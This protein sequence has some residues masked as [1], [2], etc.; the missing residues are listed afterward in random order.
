M[1]VSLKLGTFVAAVTPFIWSVVV[2][3]GNAP[4]PLSISIPERPEL[5]P[6]QP[7][8]EATGTFLFVN[9]GKAAVDIKKIVPS[10]SCLVPRIEKN[11]IDPGKDGRIILRV[12]PANESP[13]PKELFADVIYNDPEPRQVRLTFKLEIPKRQMTVRP[14]SLMFFHPKGSASTT[15]VFTVAD[16][17]KTAFDITDVECKSEFV[18]TAIGERAASASGEWSQT[19]Q[20]TVAGEL[21]EGKKQ[22]LLRIRTND[23]DYPELRV[24]LM[25]VGPSPEGAEGD[26]D[27]EHSDKHHSG[28]SKQD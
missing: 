11:Q 22:V 2:H 3:S 16:G 28:R 1:T 15:S 23:L 24:P 10:C 6:I 14:P 4:T 12:Q 17:R 13:G 7:T 21:P 26:E 8:S 27:H 5:G 9:R 20:I 18:T 25:L 19:V